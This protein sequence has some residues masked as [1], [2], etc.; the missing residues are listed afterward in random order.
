VIGRHALDR[1]TRLPGSLAVFAAAGGRVILMGQDPEWLRR[2]AGFRVARHVSRRAFPVP[3]PAFADLLAGVDGETLRDWRGAGTLVPGTAEVALDRG[4]DTSPAYGWH[5]GN[6]GSVTSAAL[7]KPHRSGWT[8][9]LEAEFDLAYTPLMELA[10]GRGLAIWCT[11]DFEGRV[12]SE[13]AANLLASRLLKHARAAPARPRAAQTVYLGGKAGE[14]LLKRVGLRFARQVRGGDPA[15]LLVVAADAALTRADFD[16]YLATGWRLLLLPRP[17]GDLPFAFRAAG[18]T[19]F[20]GSLDVPAWPECRGLS[21]SDLRLRVAIAATLLVDGPE[22][23]AGGLLGRVHSRLG[24]AILLQ[25]TPDQLDADRLTYLRYSSWRLTR[26]LA[27]LLAN[28]GGEFEADRRSLEWDGQAEVAPVPPADPWKALI[29]RPEA[30]GTGTAGR[31]AA[32]EARRGG[33][34]APPPDFY[35]AGFRTDFQLGDDPYRYYR[36]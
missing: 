4:A 33:A 15:G 32:S 26:A 17:A 2:R 29:G 1:E 3:S 16:R 27:Q 21:A 7:E 5:W 25:L 9:I 20:A 28:L 34:E 12:G 8:P 23:G 31:P 6:R 36:W 30:P 22:V 10:V 19:G 18:A 14:D 35:V 11:L 13:P 24:S